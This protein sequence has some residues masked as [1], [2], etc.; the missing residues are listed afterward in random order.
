MKHNVWKSEERKDYCLYF[1]YHSSYHFEKY[2]Y[3]FFFSRPAGS[4]FPSFH[5]SENV[6]I[7]PLIPKDLITGYRILDWQ[8]LWILTKCRV[9]SMWAHEFLWEI[10]CY[11]NCFHLISRVI[12]LLLLLE[13]SFCLSIQHLEWFDCDVSRHGFLW[14]CWDSQISRFRIFFQMWGFFNLFWWGGE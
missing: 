9:T 11:S 5:S 10:L 1:F 3:L 12:P 8:F 2:I 6:L 13:C 14:A 7:S 4:M